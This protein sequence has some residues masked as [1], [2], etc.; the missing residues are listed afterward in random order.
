MQVSW[1]RL[2]LTMSRPFRTSK[3]VRTDKET[4]WVRISDQG[5]EGWGEVVPMDTYRQTLESADATLSAIRD[6]R[7]A[8]AKALGEAVS[9]LVA[10]F[11]GQLATIAGIEAAYMDWWGKAEQVPAGRLLGIEGRNI[12][13][14]SFS[15]G[16]ERDPQVLAEK[17]LEAASYP[18]LKVKLG[19]DNDLEIIR[20]IRKEAPSATIRVD[21]NMA[22]TVDQGLALM[23]KLAELGVEF[24]EQ[25]VPAHDLEGLKRLKS[26][27]ILPIVADESCV[28]PE[29]I[30]GLRECVDGINIKLS[31][32]GGMRQ[33]LKMIQLSR[34]AGLRVMLGCMVE[35]SLGIAPA[36]H[37]AP[38]ADWLDLDGHL[39]L[40]KDPFTGIG[41][42][43]GVLRLPTE[44]GLGVFSEFYP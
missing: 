13:R 21:A 44:P 27:G 22:W 24:V 17:V 12:P 34:G 32:C 35:S 42:Q 3:A 1:T 41:G 20:T 40:A 39:L 4:I 30:S 16:I 8:S 15:L 36:V 33:G 14:T 19:L 38:L 25:P 11:D 43:N 5:V 9:G 31:K 26:A 18:I 2:Q 10:E 6:R 37:L 7:F 23:P 29:D 28:T